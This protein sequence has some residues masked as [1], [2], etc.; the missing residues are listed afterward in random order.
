MFMSGATPSEIAADATPRA[1]QNV[2]GAAAPLSPEEKLLR[3]STVG[4]YLT[5]VNA[6][7]SVSANAAGYPSMLLPDTTTVALYARADL[8]TN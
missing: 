8:V 1:R 5:H 7:T 6:D 2:T 3:A 4:A